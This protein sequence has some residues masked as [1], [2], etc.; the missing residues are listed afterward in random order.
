[1]PDIP[2]LAAADLEAIVPEQ[3]KYC[4]RRLTPSEINFDHVVPVSRGGEWAV[5][6]LAAICGSCNRRKG[7]LTHVEYL[8]LLSSLAWITRELGSNF[9]MANVL[10]RMAAGS[11]WIHR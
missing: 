7:E 8:A 6:N 5:S 2:E 4:E 9:V 11:A 3:C 1:M 10:K